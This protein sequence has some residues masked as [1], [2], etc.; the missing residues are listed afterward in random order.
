[1]KQLLIKLIVMALSVYVAAYI[2][3]GVK[4]D[5]I[6][7]LLVVSLVLGAVNAFVKPILVL[8]TLPLTIVTLGIFLLILNGALVLFVGSIVPGFHVQS[9]ISAVLFSIVVSIVSSLLSKL[10]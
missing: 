9:L 10:S 4:I 8:L 1:M 5:S 7:S 3:P 2:I 6:T